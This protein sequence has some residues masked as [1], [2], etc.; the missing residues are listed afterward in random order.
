[1]KTV[2]RRGVFE[3]N[4]SS[5]HSLSISDSHN[6]III[7]TDEDNNIVISGEFKFGWG[8]DELYDFEDKVAYYYLDNMYDEDSID[9]LKE[10]IIDETGANDVIFDI[11]E[12]YSWID[13]QSHGTTDGLTRE[14]LKDFLFNPNSYIILKNDNDYD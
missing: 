4:S 12:Y 13:H 1:M 3:T 11:N 8:Y 6:Y 7:K 5:T 9:F 2:I 10:V 14:E